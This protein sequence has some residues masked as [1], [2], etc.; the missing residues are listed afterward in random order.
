MNEFFL[1]IGVKKSDPPVEAACLS[2]WQAAEVA[3]IQNSN[4]RI[5]NS[6]RNMDHCS[7]LDNPRNRNSRN[8]NL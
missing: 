7:H 6:H 8:H 4:L 5:D 3:H 1:I 2:L